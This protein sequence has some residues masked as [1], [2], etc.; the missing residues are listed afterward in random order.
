M[1]GRFH[2]SFSMSRPAR[3]TIHVHSKL[4]CFISMQLEPTATSVTCQLKQFN[5]N[6]WQHRLHAFKDMILGHSEMN[7]IDN[8]NKASLLSH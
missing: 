1:N 5:L 2:V 6:H 7:Y 4:L 8:S 3:L